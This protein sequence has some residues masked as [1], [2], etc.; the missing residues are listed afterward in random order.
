MIGNWL[1]CLRDRV[2][3]P[4]F[5]ESAQV[6]TKDDADAGH[7]SKFKRQRLSDKGG[8][9]KDD[10]ESDTTGRGGST[11]DNHVTSLDL[12]LKLEL[13]PHMDRH[14]FV[15]TWIS[16]FASGSSV[17]SGFESAEYIF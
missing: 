13:L 8:N 11:S 10:K 2:P 5:L 1:Y 3:D 12:D 15:Q 7:S 9:Q 14:S 17:S 4:F 16:E 6:K